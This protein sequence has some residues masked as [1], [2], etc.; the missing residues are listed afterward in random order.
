M[1]LDAVAG[2]GCRGIGGFQIS[3]Y[4]VQRPCRNFMGGAAIAESC[5]AQQTGRRYESRSSPVEAMP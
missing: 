1:S 4:P 3:V 5:L 2:R